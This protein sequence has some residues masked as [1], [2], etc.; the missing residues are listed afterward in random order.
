MFG[1]G[2]PELILILAIALV[3]IGPKKLPELGRTIGKA[4]REFKK[5]TS[6]IKESI[7]S[8]LDIAELKEVKKEYDEWN[9]DIK[10]AVDFSESP[11]PAALPDTAPKISKATMPGSEPYAAYDTDKTESHGQSQNDEFLSET[12]TPIPADT[13]KKPNNGKS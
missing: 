3:V 10:E 2:L 1:I 9:R 8:E 13:E 6:E 7:N 12:D 4:M 11:T 5:A